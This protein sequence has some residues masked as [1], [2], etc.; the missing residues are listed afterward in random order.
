MPSGSQSV[1][2]GEEVCAET[3]S[4]MTV[5]DDDDENTNKTSKVTI[6]KNNRNNSTNFLPVNMILK[7]FT[8]I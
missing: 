7:L 5:G 1:Y 3:K 2:V 4:M 6:T 8:N